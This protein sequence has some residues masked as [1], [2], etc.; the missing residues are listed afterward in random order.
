MGHQGFPRSILWGGKGEGLS[1]GIPS[2]PPG[3]RRTQAEPPGSFTGSLSL[4]SSSSATGFLPGL[5]DLPEVRPSLD[6][7]PYKTCGPPLSVLLDL[8]ATSLGLLAG[9]ESAH[10]PRGPLTSLLPALPERH[11]PAGLPAETAA[12]HAGPARQN[13]EAALRTGPGAAAGPGPRSTLRRSS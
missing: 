1:K 8:P 11:E 3:E 10:R 6:P 2:S 9:T 4:N 13:R 7:S 5:G 12:P